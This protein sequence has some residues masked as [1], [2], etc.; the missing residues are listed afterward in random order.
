MSMM[1]CTLSTPYPRPTNRASSIGIECGLVDL[2]V[3]VTAEWKPGLYAATFSDAQ[4]SIYP[5]LE[6]ATNIL[7]DLAHR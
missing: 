6:L 3:Q 5:V 4:A 1:S 7:K 2:A